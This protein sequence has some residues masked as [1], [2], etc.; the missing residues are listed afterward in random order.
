MGKRGTVPLNG[1]KAFKGASAQ[2]LRLVGGFLPAGTPGVWSP[3]S[4]LQGAKLPVDFGERTRYC[5]PGHA[6]KEG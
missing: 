6:E 1:G 5:S 4:G 3:L 2:A